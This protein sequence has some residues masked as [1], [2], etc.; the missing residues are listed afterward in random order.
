MQEKGLWKKINI[1]FK[2][3]RTYNP[4]T[5]VAYAW[6]RGWLRAW[7]VAWLRAC[8]RVRQ[9]VLLRCKR[10]GEGKKKGSRNKYKKN[11]RDA[12]Q[13]VPSLIVPRSQMNANAVRTFYLNLCNLFNRVNNRVYVGSVRS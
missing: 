10:N 3:A 2:S 8:V 6:V 1:Y 5:E 11:R 9:T 4:L 12:V 13:A 7:V